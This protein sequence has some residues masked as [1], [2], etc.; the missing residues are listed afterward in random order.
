[1][2]L[3]RGLFAT[4]LL[5][6]A[7]ALTLLPFAAGMS[8]AGAR[9]DSIP[10]PQIPA[11]D[12]PAIL[13][14]VTCVTANDCWAVGYSLSGGFARTLTQHWNGTSWSVVPSPNPHGDEH[15]G[16]NSVTCNGSADCWAVGSGGQW[17]IFQHWNGSAWSTVDPPA[18]SNIGDSVVSV[19]CAS[20]SACWAVGSQYGTTRLR[21]LTAHWNGSS[22]TKVDSPNTSATRHNLLADVTCTSTTDCWAV[23]E[24][25]DNT[26]TFTLIQRWNGSAWS[27]VPS[28]SP[29]TFR[30]RLTTVT[31]LSASDC[32]AAGQFH[33]G[34]GDRTLYLRWNGQAWSFV[35]APV[36]DSQTLNSIACASTSD[37]WAVGFRE[38]DGSTLAQHWNGSAWSDEGAANP[39]DFYNVLN[40]VTCVSASDCWA[41]G[42]NEFGALIEHWD[43]TAW[44]VV[45]TPPFLAGVVSRKM[46]GN[47]GEFDIALP[48]AGSGGVECRSGGATR[49]YQ[50]VF[51]FSAP[52][53]VTG[54][55]QA[56][57]VSG[58][59][60]VGSGGVS[61]NG[62]VVVN[63]DT[64]TVPLTNVEDVRR[65]EVLLR[66]V[67]D[68]DFVRN[69]SI[70][71]A[72]L[73]GDTNGNGSVNATD[74]AQTKSQSGVPLTSANFRADVNTSGSVNASDIGQVKAKAGNTLP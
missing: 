21:T 62:S 12:T 45:T 11:G 17:P 52:I 18:N 51:S 15:H 25:R 35:L 38:Y 14:D 10:Q 53:T 23:G 28:P 13:S 70:S 4:L 8:A 61:N 7:A 42:Y 44:T 59:G 68:G 22:W 72:V 58:G 5:G 71:F 73:I 47:A 1:M 49:D 27:I 33:D 60:E 34:N 26:L 37:C 63:G 57:V 24:V 46:H 36:G 74:I 41:V 69:V 19:A 54:E 50:L 43:G 6:G 16:L 65:L 30:N 55:P 32:W 56:E 9:S 67:R 48:L 40:G 64:V 31:C 29:D 2:L 20:A 39:S 66:S 3:S